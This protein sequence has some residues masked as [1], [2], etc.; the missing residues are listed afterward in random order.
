MKVTACVI[1]KNEEKNITTWLKSM[2]LLADELIVVDTGSTD[3]TKEIVKEN[4][5]HVYDFIWQDNFAAAKNYALTKATGDWITFFDA[6][7]YFSVQVAENLKIYLRKY[8]HD[9]RVE[10]FL[11]KLI[12][13]DKDNGNKLLSSFY[14]LRIF[15]NNRDFSYVGTIHEQLKNNGKAL[16]LV[17]LPNNV[18]VY[19]TGYS[20]KIN[21]IKIKRN[22]DL[23][24]KGIALHGKNPE[25]YP[26]LANCYFSLGD[27]KKAITYLQLFIKSGIKMI[28]AELYI[29]DKYIDA[30][31]LAKCS[32]KKVVTAINDALFKYPESADLHY[33]KGI[34]LFKTKYYVA[35]EKFLQQA[36]LLHSD[37]NK[38]T[39]SRMEN[40]LFMIYAIL[41]EINVLKGEKVQAIKYFCKSLEE[42]HHSQSF[43]NLYYL[44][45]NYSVKVKIKLFNKFYDMDNIDFLLSIFM[46]LADYKLYLFYKKFYNNGMA[47]DYTLTYFVN[48]KYSLLVKKISV[49]LGNLYKKIIICLLNKEINVSTK[50]Q[51]VLP[52]I[53]IEFLQMSTRRKLKV[54]EEN[55]LLKEKDKLNMKQKNFQID[56]KLI[57]E[58][59]ENC[60][61]LFLTII[62]Q[63]KFSDQYL[64]FL[65]NSMNQ[66][67][68][69]YFGKL[70][71]LT[72]DHTD[73]YEA[74]LLAIINNM[75]QSILERYIL[76]AEDFATKRQKKII[77]TLMEKYQWRAAYVLLKKIIRK[78]EKDYNLLY[79]YA[80][81]LYYRGE[82]NSA[83]KYFLQ[84]KDAGMDENA[85]NSYLE[86]IKNGK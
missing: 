55:N 57:T 39:A 41:A 34:I 70:K 22:L 66:I 83:E 52:E 2:H 21:S 64:K 42:N 84:A 24:Q 63:N 43:M 68:L 9:A 18:F 86:W 10:G 26:Y 58:I 72:D 28:G 75:S 15:K 47:S 80:R 6:D 35:A 25:L 33:K 56:S 54:C 12:N 7:E 44:L 8:L 71:H 30:L 13:I 50:M 65:P 23:L 32:N 36:L 82:L 3:K 76:L 85:V 29:Y 31:I 74:M 48:G 77:D 51:V 69:V 38:R 46:Y 67:I 79:S 49:E 37:I 20:A 78:H 62:A 61:L 27:Y 17:T 1:V 40:Y 60:K 45:S 53:I 16:Q 59:I 14:Q 19:H 4:N 81:C 73:A 5:I 11:C